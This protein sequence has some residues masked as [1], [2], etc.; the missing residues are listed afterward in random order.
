[1]AETAPRVAVAVHGRYHAFDLARELHRM[2]HL[3]QLTTTYP[4]FA[5]R[6]FVPAPASLRTTPALELWRWAHGWAALV[7]DPDPG[8][9]KAFARFAARTLPDAA[10]VLVGWSAGVLEAIAPARERGMAVIVERGSTHISHQAETLAEEYRVFRLA[11]PAPS[12]ETIERE[13][14]EYQAADA[15]V[16]PSRFAAETFAARGI[17]PSKI[18]VNP[19]GVDASRFRAVE[20]PVRDR[21]TILFVGR[22]GLR[23][24]VP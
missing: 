2:G 6:R 11:P 18:H 3:A 12:P 21:P 14:A 15:I 7:P 5:A 1:M 8:L 22:V 24:G 16:T 23:K 19:L 4:A 9:A 20:R 10:D 17:T 13:L